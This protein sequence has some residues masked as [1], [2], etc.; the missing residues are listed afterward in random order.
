MTTIIQDA[1]YTGIG[2]ASLSAERIS[3]FIDQLSADTKVAEAEGKKIVEAWEKQA[4]N[5]RSELE[6][7]FEELKTKVQESV[8]QFSTKGVNMTVKL[9]K[10]EAEKA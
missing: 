8:D 7:Q 4:Q 2:A 10:M 1:I 6:N 9:E 3:K 5:R